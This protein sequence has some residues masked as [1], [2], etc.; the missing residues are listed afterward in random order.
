M[1]IQKGGLAIWNNRTQEFV[2]KHY[3][4]ESGKADSKLLHL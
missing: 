4:N 1:T 2:T 3:K